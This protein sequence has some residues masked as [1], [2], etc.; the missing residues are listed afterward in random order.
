MTIASKAVKTPE[1]V[2]AQNLAQSQNAGDAE[3]LARAKKGGR[4]ASF[5]WDQVPITP[6]A[7]K[8]TILGGA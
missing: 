8:P 1:T 4:G 7:A 5:L 3:R 6:T 2:N